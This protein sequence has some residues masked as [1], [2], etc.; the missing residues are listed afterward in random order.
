VA[1]APESEL[2]VGALLPSP[3]LQLRPDDVRLNLRVPQVVVQAPAQPAPA[4]QV[5]APADRFADDIRAIEARQQGRVEM[6]FEL[7]RK[8]AADGV[9]TLNGWEMPLKFWMPR[10]Y[11]GHL[12]GQVDV[13][14]LD[15]GRLS[16]NYADAIE[17]GTVAA[18]PG[19]ANLGPQFNQR[20]TGANLG[21]GYVGDDIRWDIGRTGLG[22]LIGNVVGGVR[23]GGEWGKLDYSIDASRR[24]MTGSMLSYAGVRDP[25][26]QQVWGGVVNTGAT[27]RLGTTYEGY[28]LSNNRAVWR[29]ALDRDFIKR[30][31]LQVNLGAALSFTRNT[32]DLG[33]FTWG[34]GGYYSP[35]HL[36]SL[37]FP[38]EATGQYGRFNYAIKASVSLSRSSSSDSPYYPTDAGLQAAAALNAVQFPLIAPNPMYKGGSSSGL[39]YALRALVEYPMT[40]RMLLGGRLDL[41]RA[42]YYAPTNWLVYLRYFFD[43]MTPERRKAVPSAIVPYARF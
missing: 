23:V 43:P 26:T 16:A 19:V 35:E 11:E 14:H 31:D 38:V 9:A 21:I 5:A 10:G 30:D 29:T 1:A 15:A 13:V 34:H 4:L 22:M 36:M 33:G 28:S 37:V 40:D 25:V 24:A 39:G 41:D 6:G 2:A 12:F 18:R 17:L 42:D 7:L 27:A 8:N 32:R 3:A 20:V